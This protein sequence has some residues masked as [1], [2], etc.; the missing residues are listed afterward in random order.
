MDN[1]KKYKVKKKENL[2]SVFTEQSDNSSNHAQVTQ[3]AEGELVTVKKK[4]K[5]KIVGIDICWGYLLVLP[6]IVV[7]GIH[8]WCGVG[9]SFTFFAH[10][11]CII[12][13]LLL[14]WGIIG[15]CTSDWLDFE[16]FIDIEWS[17]NMKEKVE[18]FKV[19]KP[20][21]LT[22]KSDKLLEGKE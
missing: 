21:E 5:N 2:P 10:I 20:A 18:P 1:D 13:E 15:T 6:L 22:P 19:K 12:V 17:S 4:T 3:N 8:I 9:G 16:D 7:I 11:A 14:F